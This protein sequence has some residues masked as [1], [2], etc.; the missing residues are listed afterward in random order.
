MLSM[1]GI[2]LLVVLVFGLL[3]LACAAENSLPQRLSVSNTSCRQSSAGVRAV[4]LSEYFLGTPYRTNTLG[5]GPDQKERLTVQLEAVDCFTLIDYVEAL[6]RIDSYDTFAQAL[7]DVRYRNHNVS[8][9]TRR[10]YF[11][12]WVES[13]LIADV[14][15]AVAGTAVRN[16]TKTL[17]RQANGESLLPAVPIRETSLNYIPTEAINGEVVA[18]LQAGDYVG[19]YSVKPWLD[20]SH[21]GLL[22]FRD[23]QPYLRHASS[24]PATP[25]VIDSPLSEYLQGKPGIIV[26]R[27]EVM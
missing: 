23:G 12:D 27:P 4:C 7:I 10:H 5:G 11:S 3:P 26:L 2:I 16:V 20:V 17:N 14:T 6:R 19:I 18:R 15:I 1:R 13:P 25:Y 21:V 24:Q 22:V 8:W 9:S